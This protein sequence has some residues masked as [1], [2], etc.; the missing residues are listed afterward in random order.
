M[1]KKLLLGLWIAGFLVAWSV[2][3]VNAQ[4]TT[5]WN[6]N[7]WF[8]PNSTTDIVGV[9]WEDKWGG[10]IDTIKS[11]IN[12]ILWLLSLIALIMLLFG[13]FKMVTAAGDEEKY[14]DGFKVIKQAWIWLAVIGLSWFIVSIIFWVIGSSTT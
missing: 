5:V 8:G 4:S 2:S 13:G 7:S 3:I 1:F 12:W 9:G 6:D 11:V 14:K 10:L